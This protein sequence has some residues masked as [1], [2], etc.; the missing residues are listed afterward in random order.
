M[1]DGSTVKRFELKPVVSKF[2]DR[3]QKWAIKESHWMTPY[4]AESYP[5]YSV[6]C[7]KV[8]EFFVF[9]VEQFQHEK[10][11]LMDGQMVTT[12]NK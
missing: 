7:T 3:W 1:R 12:I 2:K 10:D 8:S 4:C 9:L 11:I 6:T 5:C